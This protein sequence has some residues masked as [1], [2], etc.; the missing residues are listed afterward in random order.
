MNTKL[1]LFIVLFSLVSV[2][3]LLDAED[4][5]PERFFTD[6]VET[7]GVPEGVG[8]LT[9][10]DAMT[11]Q[12]YRFQYDTAGRVVRV[13]SLDPAGRI[14]PDFFHV[15][16]LTFEYDGDGSLLR[17]V[18]R[19]PEGTADLVWRY[20]G[21]DRIFFEN[22]FLGELPP[23]D[24]MPFRDGLFQNLSECIPDLTACG[25]LAGLSFIRDKEGRVV[26][27]DFLRADGARGFDSQETAGHRYE[28]DDLGRFTKA[29]LLNGKGEPHADSFGVA[30]YRLRYEGDHPVEIGCF[31]VDGKPVNNNRGFA[32]LR[33]EMPEPGRCKISFFDANGDPAVDRQDG[34]SFCITSSRFDGRPDTI[35]FFGPDGLPCAGLRGA[36]RL[37]FHY[38]DKNTEEI[39]LTAPDGLSPWSG[40]RRIRISRNRFGRVI[41]REFFPD[42][43]DVPGE[44][45]TDTLSE[46]GLLKEREIRKAG[47]PAGRIREVRRDNGALSSRIS[48][49]GAGRVVREEHFDYDRLGNWLKYWNSADGGL[50]WELDEDGRLEKRIGLDK[51]GKDSGPSVALAYDGS[52]RVRTETV[53]PA[54]SGPA[55]GIRK[56]VYTW[57]RRGNPVR[58]DFFRADGTP[59]EKG[60]ASILREFDD[61]GNEI[62][63]RGV[64]ASGTPALLPGKS[65]AEIRCTFD[66]RNNMTAIMWLDRELL[67][68]F[69]S[70]ILPSP[71]DD[72]SAAILRMQHDSAGNLIRAEL[73]PEDETGFPEFGGAAR[74]RIERK[75]LSRGEEILLTF[76]DLSGA[77]FHPFG[78]RV[79]ALR[80]RDTDGEARYTFLDENME[81]A[82]APV[83]G[84]AEKVF[85]RSSDT[86]RYY[87]EKGNQVMPG[88]LQEKAEK[89]EAEAPA[90]PAA[91]ANGGPAR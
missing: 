41:R 90:G 82:P 61:R 59:P 84:Y 24:F 10:Q 63:V 22:A 49:D 43:S 51:D 55:S 16:V 88:F 29:M 57:D 15:R 47:G 17:R 53:I 87:D 34:Y 21:R 3:G 12:R 9:G 83:L 67:P 44:V 19:S 40:I 11:R 5:L 1:R 74:V 7:F 58:E 62:L 65:C 28:R 89:G 52:G 71:L 79:T 50:R 4:S 20:E 30:E 77:P 70:G 68:V 13:E 56:T 14:T 42:E 39:R 60:L 25:N 66:L 69:Q 86:P 18:W 72:L 35:D 2:C 38:P 36:A 91:P 75:N 33:Q 37:D 31:G 46:Y 26:R 81:T 45:W 6:M 64:T 27:A 76:Y 32:F 78:G 54:S 73:F 80:F 23:L 48:L 85:D 8:P